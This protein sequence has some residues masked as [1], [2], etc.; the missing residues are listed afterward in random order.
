MKLPFFSSFFN[1][2]SNSLQ[3]PSS[4]LLKELKRTA[5]NN[6]F[7]IFENITIYHHEKSFTIPLLIVDDTRGIFL[8]EYKDWSYDDLKNAKIEKASQ[9]DSSQDTLAF[10]KKHDFIKQKFNELTHNDGVP[11]FNYLLMENFNHDQY[12]HLDD[13][14]KELLPEDRIMFSDSSQEDILSKMVERV[15]Y[16]LPNVSTIMS[17]LLIQYAVIGSNKNI[18]LASQEQMDFIDSPLV[19]STVLKSSFGTGKTSAILLKALLEKLKDPKLEIIILKPTHIACD[20][21]KKQLLDTIE[22]AI[23][24]VDPT[25]IKIMTEKDFTFNAPRTDLLICDDVWAYSDEFV[26]N[27]YN[28]SRSKYLIMVENSHDDENIFTQN[29]RNENKEVFFHQG[30]EHAKA[31]QIIASLLNQCD[32]HDILVVSDDLTRE[33]LQDDL[34][35][36]VEQEITLV[37][38]S[39]PLVDHNM[40]QII[41]STYSHINSLETK[42]VILMNIASAEE[43]NLQYAY[44]L[45]SQN[46][47]ILY[48]AESENLT[49]LRNNFENN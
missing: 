7:S 39:Q 46:V 35:T 2:N 48:D 26:L 21:L 4:L 20:I 31:L 45:C 33:R 23:V 29:F 32:P 44:N 43:K 34:E 15:T 42:Y 14:F 30:N 16:N 19:E 8:F 18:F 28:A 10:E 6:N 9:Q 47:Y 41:L 1:Q 25:S 24:E 37:D 5:A 40:D 22:H 17:T 38:S 49:S 13:S 27:I 3:L 36:F 12:Q 11:L